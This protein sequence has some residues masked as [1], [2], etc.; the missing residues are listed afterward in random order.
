MF[1][2]NSLKLPFRHVTGRTIERE[3]PP[4]SWELHRYDADGAALCDADFGCDEMGLSHNAQA[5]G[6]PP[7]DAPPGLEDHGRD[8][9][10][11][12]AAK[13]PAPRKCQQPNQE[14]GLL[15]KIGR[16]TRLFFRRPCVDGTGAG[17]QPERVRQGPMLTARERLV[18]ER[19]VR[20]LHKSHPTLR[21]RY[22]EHRGPE[23]SSE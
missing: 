7:P 19:A 10:D 23:Y 12:S 20:R 4:T 8:L 15:C 3:F 17:C 18:G 5:Y 21:R 13:S 14:V 11:G 22:S 1:R 16:R 6:S 9:L 2:G